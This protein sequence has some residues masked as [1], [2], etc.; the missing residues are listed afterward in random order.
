MLKKYIRNGFFRWAVYLILFLLVLFFALN[1]LIKYRAREIIHNVVAT[2][3]QGKA[4]VRIGRVGLSLFPVTRLDLF[5]TKLEFLD[6]T[7]QQIV[8]DISFKYL[9]LQVNSITDFLFRKKLQIDFLVAE[10]PHIQINPSLKKKQQPGNK[11]VHFE[12]GNIYLALQNIAKEMQIRRFGLLN[13]KVTLLKL[14]PDETNIQIG[15]VNF[16]AR[17]LMMNPD[18]SLA[19]ESKL[20]V[21][22]LR[23]NTGKQEIRFPEG[24]YTIHFNGLF[25]DTEEKLVTIND[26]GFLGKAK[27]TALGNIEAGF[28]QFRMYN[29]DFW[30]LYNTGVLKIDSLVCL[31][32]KIRMGLDLGHKNENMSTDDIHIERKIAA[33]TGKLDIK[34]LA[35]RNSTID[36]T[37]RNK[38]KITPFHSS[39][40]DFEIIGI[41][42]DSAAARPVDIEKVSFAIKHYTA[43]SSDSMYNVN[44]DSVVFANRSINLINFR[45]SP[46][47]KNRS[48]AKKWLKVP[49]FQLKNISV[50]HLMSQKKLKATELLLEEAEIV[51]YFSPKVKK[52]ERP[53]P[54]REIIASLHKSID[55][56]K[57]H[58]RNGSIVMQSVE[59]KNKRVTVFGLDSEISLEEMF[60][61]SSYE[62]MGRSIGLVYFDSLHLRVGDYNLNFSKGEVRGKQSL[63][64]AK[65]MNLNNSYTGARSH[66]K[67]IRLVNYRF[68]DEF[69][70]ISI[71]SLKFSYAS[72]HLRPQKKSTARKTKESKPPGFRLQHFQGGD[73]KIDLQQADTLLVKTH[74]NDIEASGI[75]LIDGKFELAGLL[76]DMDS[77]H[78]RMPGIMARTGPVRIVDE[79][80]STISQ[81]QW[82]SEK[83]GTLV[84]AE[85]PAIRF[86]PAIARSIASKYPVI[87]SVE[88]DQ[89]DIHVH[90]VGKPEQE[91]GENKGNG[92]IELGELLIRQGRLDIT[93]EN[94]NRSIRFKT[95]PID[96]TLRNLKKDLGPMAFSMDHGSLRTQKIDFTLNDSIRLYTEEGLLDMKID[97]IGKRL[98]TEGGNFHAG[99]TAFEGKKLNLHLLTKKGKAMEINGFS[100]GGRDL[101]LD[102]MQVSHILRKMKYNPSLYAGDIN[103]RKIDTKT[104]LE[105]FGIGFTNHN[106]T[107]SIDSLIY[108]PSMDRDSFNR[109]QAWQKDYFEV[110]TGRIRIRNF[111]FDRM[112]SDSL[113]NAGL[114]EIQKPDLHIYKD[115]RLPFQTGIIKPLP[116]NM[117]KK[118]DKRLRL[119][120]L[121][122][123]DGNLV[124][125]E[126]NDKTNSIG[127]VNF[128][129]MN[130]S[131]RN[132]R[133]YDIKGKDSLMLS[134]STKFLDKAR[135]GLRYRESYTDSLAG[136]MFQVN[137][138]K[139]DL[140]ELTAVTK[141]LA[142]ARVSKGFLDTLQLKA[143]G[144]ENIAHGK[145]RM[146]Y[147]DLKVEFLNKE[148]QEKKTIM[149]RLMTWAA[150]LIVKGSN[151]SRTGTVYTQRIRERSVFNYWIK[152]VL[153]GALTNAGIKSNSKQDKKYKKSVRKL[154][155]PEIPEVT[156]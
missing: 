72:L 85:I 139:M 93:R 61:A 80:P 154:N 7:K 53:K 109:M 73:I 111:D 64:K 103:F 132:I 102:S 119:D 58:I 142:N 128:T 74:I 40:N 77:L 148:D 82:S 68:N 107:I 144:R 114:I 49:N 32:P 20:Q 6:S 48:P 19:V 62:L 98:A 94:G 46:S 124:Y 92:S 11:A 60:D 51:N 8:Y 39:G 33:L 24:N 153:S 54:L 120:S 117:L 14:S 90:L 3:T 65:H 66:A 113:Y 12:I 29:L 52:N 138:G 127:T 86:V 125:E 36:I 1:M 28:R 16:T 156:L 38:D 69:N 96:I 150:N 112:A 87:P 136:F 26:F 122:I 27:D 21:G 10:D 121:R 9:G 37:T 99:L 34:Y 76:V 88:L 79:Q 135:L 95:D 30:S 42:I 22:R 57:V 59:D 145:M 129:Q 84:R 152:I 75:S 5:N 118:I 115:K 126:Y 100:M 141:P 134:A 13:G 149:T 101:L 43:S 133:N 130:A 50:N 137:M 81:I 131:I 97:G 71:D 45:I 2:Q 23:L 105:V 44:F 91:G 146:L 83:K 15:G 67:D 147:R 56:D 108:H 143:I 89:P 47:D 78:L 70:M 151:T 155:V 41:R 110:A 4:D 17:D 25:L 104:H 31:D 35:L 106:K 116:V 18:S 140:S 55:L 123:V 63:I